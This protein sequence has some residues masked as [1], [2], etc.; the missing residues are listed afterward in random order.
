MT[1]VNLANA[2][3]KSDSDFSLL[4]ENSFVNAVD[5]EKISFVSCHHSNNSDEGSRAPIQ[6]QKHCFDI[7]GYVIPEAELFYLCIYLSAARRTPI[8]NQAE[9]L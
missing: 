6:K 5:V 9:R 2:Q 7:Q 3:Q 1:L 4:D 8:G